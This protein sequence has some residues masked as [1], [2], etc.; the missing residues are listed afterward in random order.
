M[1]KRI[2]EK[3]M[4]SR[5]RHEDSQFSKQSDDDFFKIRP[6]PYNQKPSQT[7][8][9]FVSS[10]AKLKSNHIKNPDLDKY[11]YYDK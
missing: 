3:K 10:K 8:L 5:S 6:G 2:A 4:K 7:R 9:K 11:S 1:K